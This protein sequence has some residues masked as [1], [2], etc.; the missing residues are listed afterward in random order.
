MLFLSNLNY[1]SVSQ[2]IEYVKRLKGEYIVYHSQR[3][4]LYDFTTRKN[5]DNNIDP[6][7]NRVH[8]PND[9]AYAWCQM[10]APELWENPAD[11]EEQLTGFFSN[12]IYNANLAA[13]QGAILSGCSHLWHVMQRDYVHSDGKK[14]TLWK[15]DKKSCG[16][17][18]VS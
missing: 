18:V 1:L 9:D 15:C 6:R 8:W 11:K 4:N 14:Y 16:M 12:T 17:L 2:I 13:D 10:Y 7:N 5:Y 3:T